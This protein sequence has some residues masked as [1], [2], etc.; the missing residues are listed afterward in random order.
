MSRNLQFRH[1][2]SLSNTK[3][4]GSGL[5]LY[6]ALCRTGSAKPLK[7]QGFP[8]GTVGKN[9]LPVQEMQATWV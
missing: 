8:S 3:G 1:R 6:R 2:E 4:R 9:L 5:S 7:Q